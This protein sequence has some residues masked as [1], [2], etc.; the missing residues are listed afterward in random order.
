MAQAEGIRLHQTGGPE[1]LHFEEW[2]VPAP[3]GDEILIRHD[4]VGVNFIDTYQRSGLYPIPLP[5]GLGLEAA[6]TIE[7]IGAGVTR[8][9]PGDRAAYCT[10]PVGAY[11]TCHVVKE[12]RAIALPDEIKADHAAAGMLKG[13]TAQYLIRQIYPVGPND[14][15]LFHAAAGG[16]GQI[17]V[18]WLA[19]LGATVIATAG[20]AEKCA[21]A[22]RLGATHIIDYNKEDVPTRV[23]EITNDAGVPVVFDSVGK[24]TWLGSLD[25]LKPR[26]LMVSFG[27]ASGPVEGVNLGILSQKGSLFVTRPTLFHY[28]ATTEA[29]EA[30][31]SDFFATLIAGDV[32][33]SDPTVYPLSEA[34]QAHH[35]LEAR[36][37]TGSLILRP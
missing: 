20:G 26:G 25:S 7:A 35:D 9:R 28:T 12:A 1:V 22:K 14:T 5:G 11:A 18:Q 17:A 15:V 34:A 37:T 27:N 36:R 29:L 8:F 31:A 6:G 32:R 3:S 30:A 19:A 13:L 33:I 21:L 23:R 24:A 16:V 10:G 2:E 4:A